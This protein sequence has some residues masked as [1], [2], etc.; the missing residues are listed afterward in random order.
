MK[1]LIVEDARPIREGLGKILTRLGKS[2]EVVGMAADGL[3]G[4][5]MIEEYTPDLVIMDIQMPDM[6]GLTMLEKAR[7]K[8]V[9]CHFVVL[10]AY[11][12]FNY[13]QKA[14]EL[15]V[16]NYLLK[17]IKIPELKRALTQVEEAILK[18]LNPAGVYT[19]SYIFRGALTGNLTVDEAL[20]HTAVSQYGLH[21]DDPI[22]LFIVWLGDFYSVCQPAAFMILDGLGEADGAFHSYLVE[23]EE[24]QALVLCIYGMKDEG[25]TEAYLRQRVVPML[26]SNLE[27][28]AV[29]GWGICPGLTGLREQALR[30]A[31]DMEWN[32]LYENQNP[33]LITRGMVEEIVTVPLR[34]P[35]ELEQ[36]ARY[37]AA[38]KNDGE[39]KQCFQ[40]LS[41]ACSAQP[42]SPG[43]IKDV[44]LRFCFTVLNAARE[45]GLPAED[46]SVQ[47]LSLS[48]GRASSWK[49]LN[50]ILE[51]FQDQLFAGAE[52]E[53]AEES[54][55]D[56]VKKAQALIRE[57]YNQGITLEEIARKLYVTEEY[58]SA[59]IRKETGQTFTEIIRQSRMAEIKKLLLESDLK[60]NQIAAMT[61]YSD[62]K[63]MSK[64]FREE[65][66]MSP[67]E[68]RK[69]KI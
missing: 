42:H 2:Y 22:G 63:Y 66:G 67:A 35:P 45:Y 36:K 57:Y 27:G 33:V 8:K 61:G 30:I 10:T 16:D 38:H 25:R 64:V 18:T 41:A 62:P 31:A 12:D 54:T 15:G 40:T 11:S 46:V 43:E 17:P 29:Y 49:V 60:L 37:A 48:I 56:L 50:G 6:D 7:E 51:N 24:Q 53:E 65:V 21:A 28:R 47:A 55:S 9:E 58:L 19:R 34:L 26:S 5:Q 39:V 68:Y 23:M 59:Q 44:C 4:L 32:L 3:E 13:A 14:I 69:M 20:E 52:E 1:I